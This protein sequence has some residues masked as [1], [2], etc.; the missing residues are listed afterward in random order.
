[1][2][3]KWINKVVS[4]SAILLLCSVVSLAQEQ[5]PRQAPL[6]EKQLQEM[7]KGKIHPPSGAS[8]QI[9]LA[10]GNQFYTVLL[11]DG[12]RYIQEP[13]TH[14]QLP[15]LEAIVEAAREFSLTEE[16]AGVVQP[17]VT[18]FSDEQLPSFS[19][20]VAKT[21]KQ[22]RYYITMKTRSGI[23]TVDGGSIRRDKPNDDEVK[24]LFHSIAEQIKSVKAQQPA[25]GSDNPAQIQ[26]R[27]PQ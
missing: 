25:V 27:P 19:I 22:S 18:R 8:F 4:L 17:I 21:G 5:K 20:D 2:Q 15:V 9:S 1:M 3:S 24:L 7:N 12:G 16:K 10:S 23:L 13:F 14:N 6:T 26:L 11:A